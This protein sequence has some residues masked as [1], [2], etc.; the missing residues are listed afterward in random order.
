MQIR[1]SGISAMDHVI[2]AY[3]PAYKAWH[4]PGA[5]KIRNGKTCGKYIHFVCL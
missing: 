3:G 2:D 4:R 5:G 1:G